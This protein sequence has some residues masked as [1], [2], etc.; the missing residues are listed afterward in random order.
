MRGGLRRCSS[1]ASPTEHQRAD[2]T[3]E[4]AEV[5]SGGGGTSVLD[6]VAGRGPALAVL[7]HPDDESFG[8]G[9]VLAALTAA[10]TV[11]RGGV[12]DLR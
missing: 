1:G 4:A 3:A 10:G 8:L 9:A 5:F 11:V 2:A 12:P 6:D 7:A